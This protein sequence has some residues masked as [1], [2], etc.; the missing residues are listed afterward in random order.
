ME[1]G[2]WERGRCPS[3]NDLPR[4]QQE[5]STR[6]NYNDESRQISNPERLCGTPPDDDITSGTYSASEAAFGFDSPILELVSLAQSLCE[7]AVSVCFI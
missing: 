7:L 2:G 3:F 1:R 4:I 6:S 5:H